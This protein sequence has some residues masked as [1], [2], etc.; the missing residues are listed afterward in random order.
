MEKNFVLKGNICYS[1]D[2]KH[3]EV[4]ENGFLVCMDGKSAGVYPVLPERFKDLE[5]T[6]YGDKLIIPGLTDLHAHAPQYAF[7]GLGMDLELLEWLNTHTF[8]EEAKYADA[9]YAKKAYEIYTEDLKK[10]ATTRACIFATL[11]VDATI[12]LMDLLEKTG[13]KTMVGK[14]N[15][16]R[17]SPDYLCEESAEA[18]SQATLF[19]I[20]KVEN[21]YK[22]TRPIITP[23][24]IPTCSD[25]LMTKLAA[26]QKKFNLPMQSHLSENQGEI[27]WVRELSKDAAFYGDAYDRFDMFGGECRT[28]MAHCVSSTEEEIN[29]MQ[30]KGVFIAHCPQSNA[31]LSSGAAPVRTYLDR[32]MN[33]GLG[34][35]LAG[36]ASISVLET[37]KDAIQCSKLRWRMLDDTLPA[38]TFEEAFYLATKGGGSFFGKVGSF[39]EDYE[40][41]AVVLEDSNL[42][43]PQ[44]LGAKDRLE[45]MIY[46]ADDRN[47]VG[48]YTAGRKIF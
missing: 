2:K 26:I 23:R 46:L 28:I 35:D 42:R 16:D 44:E 43:H 48:K 25:E 30:E 37:V 41:D 14:V 27:A 10:S 40:L 7:R 31:N 45:R 5:V 34:T 20:S 19:W 8:Q 22:N 3:M 13:L 21:R 18:S 15:M 32:D 29:R 6:D 39:E 47:I 4:V 9:D 38:L 1:T 33:V 11:H 24:F 36:G 12:M 17:N